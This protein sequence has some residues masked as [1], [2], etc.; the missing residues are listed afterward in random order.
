MR[1]EATSQEE[2]FEVW[3]Y[4]AMRIFRDRLV[5]QEHTARFDQMIYNQLSMTLGY[6]GKITSFYT[7]WT[8][9]KTAEAAAT[10]V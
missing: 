2:L 5:G 3:G 6:Q 9:S 1:Y 10:I 7:T 4:E 8:A